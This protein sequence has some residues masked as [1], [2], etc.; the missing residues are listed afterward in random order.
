MNRFTVLLA[1]L[2]LFA[3]ATSEAYGQVP[4][5]DPR[6]PNVLFIAVDDLNNYALGLNHHATAKTPHLDQLAARGTLFTN[7]HCAAPGCN[8]SRASV[9]TGVAP[10]NSGVYVNSQDWRECRRLAEITTL[11]QHFRDHGYKVIG[12]GKLYHAANLRESQLEGFLDA[13]PWHE[14][15]PSRSRQLA[16]DVAPPKQA[17]NGSNEFYGGRFDWKKLDIADNEMGDGKV[18]SWAE[19]QLSQEHGS[20]LFLGVGIYRPHIPWY[21]P[22]S[23]FD[24]NPIS[25]VRLPVGV[26]EDL[27]DIPDPGANFVRQPWHKWLVDNDKWNDATQAYLA[28]VGFADAMVGRLIKALDEGPLADNTIVVLWSDHGYHLGHK[29][30]WEKFALWNQTTHVPMIVVDRRF[31]DSSGRCN[32]PASLLDLYP[33]LTEL[34]GLDCPAH[35]DGESLVPFLKN[36]S[37]SS[38]RAV[39]ITHE[40][41]NHAV[42]SRHWR[43]IRYFDGSQEL[44]DH[45][46]D[47]GERDNLAY[48][49][50]HTDQIERLAKHLPSSSVSEDPALK[51]SANRLV[52]SLGKDRQLA[53][54]SVSNHSHLKRESVMELHA[55]PG[56]SVFDDD[57]RFLYIAT[58]NPATITVCKS[59]GI[60]LKKVHSVAIPAKPSFLELTPDGKN[61]IAAYY[62]TGQVTVHRVNDGGLLSQ[63]PLQTLFANERAHSVAI[64]ADGR[65]VFISH[66]LPNSISQFWLDS[67]SGQLTQNALGNLSTEPNTGPRHLRFH[68]GG[69]FAYGSNEQG[70]SVSFYR[71]DAELGTLTHHQ[72][73]SSLPPDY[74]GDATTSDIEVHPSGRFVY[75]ANRLHGSIAVFSVAQASGQL[76]KIQTVPT[77]RVTRSF[78]LSPSGSYLVA[79]GQRSGN[80]VAYKISDDGTLD[81]VTDWHAGKSINWISFFPSQSKKKASQPARQ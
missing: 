15:F 65:S 54:F 67:E 30:H 27:S 43:Y 81:R 41:N 13:R 80:L 39:V 64:S 19:S 29:R 16:D 51:P 53:T 55:Q 17:A 44:Y 73:I 23:Y 42:Q 72:T 1:L 28:S 21:T 46:V 22:R 56:A 12:G 71:L 77:E 20:P 5:A 58:V 52:V 66:T 36:P 33:T 7:A 6:R 79:G 63:Q 47:P 3:A 68:P 76:T 48:D 4:P 18:V 40:K 69:R 24:A 70:C 8:P 11:P 32:R 60:G 59:V 45:R 34:C 75:I 2:P 10:F 50:E 61:L 38:D 25:E 62:S 31:A 74:I 35:L 9:M 78:N 37:T 14:Y 26:N 49:A 57:G